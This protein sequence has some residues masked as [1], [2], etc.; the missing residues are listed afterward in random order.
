MQWTVLTYSI[1]NLEGNATDHKT[2]TILK[3]I[4]IKSTNLKNSKNTKKNKS[5]YT[6]TI[7]KLQENKEKEI[8]RAVRKKRHVSKGIRQLN[9]QQQ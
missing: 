1:H 7:N 9:F 4:I 6:L 5:V 8:L 2:H 3:D